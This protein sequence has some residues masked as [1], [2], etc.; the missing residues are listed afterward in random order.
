[1]EPPPADIGDRYALAGRVVSM[2]PDVAVLAA[3]LVYIEGETIA[4][5]VPEGE[6]AP[7]GFEDAPVLDTAGTIYPGLIDL[8]NHSAYSAHPMWMMTRRYRDRDHWPRV[9][10]Y[11]GRVTQPSQR[12]AKVAE[13]LVRFAEA[14]L[15]VGGVT[16]GMRPGRFTI[17]DP[18][19]RQI[20]RPNHPMLPEVT[21]RVAPLDERSLDRL[22]EQLAKRRMLANTAQGIDSERARREL[23]R[24]LDVDID[25]PPGLALVGCSAARDDDY[26]RMADRG[27]ALVWTPLSDLVLYGGTIDVGA[28]GD[29][30]VVMGLGSTWPVTGSKNLLG[31]LKAAWATNRWWGEPFDERR[32][33]AMATIDA[34]SILG[35][36]SAL[37][38]VAPGK[39]ADLVVVD[40]RGGDPHDHLIMATEASIELVV[41]GGRPRY[42]RP[43]WLR[44]CGVD[45][46]PWTVGSTTRAVARADG[47]PTLA[48]SIEPVA[49]AL[50]EFGLEPDPLT[51]DDD[52]RFFDHLNRQPNIPD[53]VLSDL[54]VAYGEW[55]GRP[56]A[57][58]ARVSRA[59]P[60]Y[61]FLPREGPSM[62][63]FE[64]LPPMER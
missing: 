15:L 26:A 47:L 38:S 2:D 34:A 51:V 42:G 27:L 32:L 4:E 61:G 40:G 19:V 14:K 28:A 52:P 41:V 23:L 33:V 56:T 55:S 5:V 44:R 58:P 12:L 59:Q 16:S 54:L 62:R 1:T 6:P 10:Q 36:D 7:P 13:A 48:E 64:A 50:A 30:R 25:L 39:L 29:R 37:G 49:A 17:G 35:W 18:A 57:V 31:E 22:P 21:V 63:R 3:G 53:E 11:Q 9:V 20:R 46:E 24:V 8:A 43:D 45:A 60:F